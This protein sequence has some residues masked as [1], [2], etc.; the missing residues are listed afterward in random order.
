MCDCLCARVV[1]VMS[2]G[3]LG[4]RIAD[5]DKVNADPQELMEITKTNS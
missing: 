1:D 4:G 3:E 2:K 5:E